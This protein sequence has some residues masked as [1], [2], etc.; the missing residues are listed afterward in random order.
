[1]FKPTIK[2]QTLLE[3]ARLCRK[4]EATGDTDLLDKRINLCRSLSEEAFG[5]DG[6]W[7]SFEEFIGALC[8]TNPLMDCCTDEKLCEIFEFIGYGVEEMGGDQKTAVS[9]P[10]KTRQSEFLKIYPNAEINGFTGAIAILPCEMDRSLDLDGKRC[11]KYADSTSECDECAKDY[12]EEE[13]E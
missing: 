7:L 8:E 11:K 13:V 6:Y 12:W 2:K 4:Y 10:A 5:F 1:M 3:A 9:R